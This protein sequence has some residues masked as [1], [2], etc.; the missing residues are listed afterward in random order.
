MSSSITSRPAS[1]AAR[2]GFLRQGLAGL[3]TAALLA[4][5]HEAHSA[6]VPDKGVKPGGVLVL[7]DCDP[8]YQGKANY[9]DNLSFY[10]SAGKLVARVTGLNGCEEI[11]S[12]HKIA[13]DASRKCVWLVENVGHRLLK[14]DLKGKQLLAVKDVSASALAVD[15]AT[16]NVWV[17]RSSGRI[18]AGST[19]VRDGKGRLLAQYTF[20]GWDIAYD[21][22]GK[23]FWLAEQD[24]LK[25]SLAG[26]V[27]VRKRGVA[28]WCSSSL[29]VNQKTGAVWVATRRYSR[30]N[31]VNALLGFDNAGKQLHDIRLEAGA[32]FRVAVDSTSGKVWVAIFRGPVLGFTAQGK[33][34][35]EHKVKALTADVEPGTGN[36]WVVTGTEVLKLDKK[37]KVLARARHAGKTTQAWILGY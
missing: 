33:A 3:A 15:P 25:V 30:G 13:I 4:R 32:P 27:V 35:G 19:E 26:E 6:P 5:P 37:S 12:P 24:L 14:Y 21:A 22:K 2:R 7:D 9:A 18:G 29:A 16:G 11:G 20:Y 8:E 28:A 1:L 17:L 34:E 36:V 31:G 10:D 23:S